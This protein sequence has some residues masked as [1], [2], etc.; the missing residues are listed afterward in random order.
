MSRAHRWV[1]VLFLAC[2]LGC[3]YQESVEPPEDITA[4]NF[5]RALPKVEAYAGQD[6]SLVKIEAYYVRS[7]GTMDLTAD[8][9][10]RLNYTFVRKRAEGSEDGPIGTGQRQ[11]AYEVIEVEVREPGWLNINSGGRS[12]STERHKGMNR[13]ISESGEDVWKART[14]PPKCDVKEVWAKAIKKVKAPK[15]AVAIITYERG[16]YQFSIHDV[17]INVVFDKK[18]KLLTDEEAR[19]R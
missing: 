9:R 18:C 19:A 16:G 7:D 1:V 15:N 14:P 3:T 5:T 6:A 2:G 13:R 8:Y 4:F 17:D 10:P 12:N 11:R